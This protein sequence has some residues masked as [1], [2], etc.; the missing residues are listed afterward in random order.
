MICDGMGTG[1]EARLTS[2]MCTNFLEKILKVSSEKEIAL[3][4]LNNFVRSKN[5]ECSSSVD[6]LEIDLIGRGASFLKSGASPSFIKRGEKVFRLLSKTAPVGIMRN[7]DAERLS[8]HFEKGDICVMLSDGVASGKGDTHW[9]N[10]YLMETE[11]T[12][13]DVIANEILDLAKIHNKSQD[14]TRV[15]VILFE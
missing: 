2:E 12:D 14:D 10:N 13:T 11:S 6:L 4:I 15:I 1:D 8:F 9:I 7:L 5:M 3:S